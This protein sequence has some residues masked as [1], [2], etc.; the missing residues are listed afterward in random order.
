MDFVIVVAS[1]VIDRCLD[2][3]TEAATSGV[4]AA[5]EDMLDGDVGVDMGVE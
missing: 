2:F 4:D 1:E 3:D 5:E